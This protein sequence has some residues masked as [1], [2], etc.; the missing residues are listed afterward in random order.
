MPN[1]FK[2]KGYGSIEIQGVTIQGEGEK[3]PG[4]AA[5][6]FVSQKLNLPV[7]DVTEISKEE[8]DKLSKS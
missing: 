2:A 4:S 8:Y 7:E 1:Y 5:E 6:Q 3:G